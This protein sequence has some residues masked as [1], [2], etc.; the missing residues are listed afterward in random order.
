VRV[1]VQGDGFS[2]A[3][4]IRGTFVSGER[5][6]LRVEVGGLVKKDLSLAWGS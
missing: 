5:Q 3:R 1:Q 4:R 2:D 6:R